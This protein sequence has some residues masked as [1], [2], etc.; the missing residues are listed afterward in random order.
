MFD[1]H[2]LKNAD[3]FGLGNVVIVW[4]FVWVVY[5]RK[6]HKSMEINVLH[7]LGFVIN[8]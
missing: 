3:L 6:H 7:I 2:Y 1:I 5:P 4:V 8:V